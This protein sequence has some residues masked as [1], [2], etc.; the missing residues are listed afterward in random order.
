MEVEGTNEESVP[1]G[2]CVSGK[3]RKAHK[4]RRRERQNGRV[5]EGVLNLV[6]DECDVRFR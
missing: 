2:V 4:Q 5:C 3:E 1:V 6:A